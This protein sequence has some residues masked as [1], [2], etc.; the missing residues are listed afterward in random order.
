MA[1]KKNKKKY[2]ERKMIWGDNCKIYCAYS[3]LFQ[4]FKGMMI[5]KLFFLILILIIFLIVNNHMKR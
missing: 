3:F 4:F 2:K 1:K 5:S